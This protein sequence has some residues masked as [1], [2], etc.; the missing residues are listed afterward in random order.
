[1]AG[2]VIDA[3]RG[4]QPALHCPGQV[5]A[6][7]PPADTPCSRWDKLLV[8]VQG[9]DLV[10][11]PPADAADR[12]LANLAAVAPTH[13][14][15]ETGA[16]CVETRAPMLADPGNDR[17]FYRFPMGS[18]WKGTLYMQSGLQALAKLGKGSMQNMLTQY[19]D[20]ARHRPDSDAALIAAVSFRESGINAWVAGNKRI[21]T[22]SGGGLDFLGKNL[23]LMK[24]KY[25]PPGYGGSWEQG[26]DGRNESGMEAGAAYLPQHDLPV[27]YGAWLLFAKDTFEAAARKYGFTQDELDHM[28]TDARRAWVATFFAA[29]GGVEHSQPHG[30]NAMQIGGVT[31]LTHLKEIMAENKAKGLPDRGLD[32]ILTDRELYKYT[33]VRLAMAVVGNAALIEKSMGLR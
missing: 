8:P 11:T 9:F 16:A 21:D 5:A 18:Q 14:N 6:P 7:P 3:T 23:G 15:V 27:A 12:A 24:S 17:R 26:Y 4:S 2:Q 33:N 28:S 10:S 1:M 13:A 31:V 25:L 32:D 29:G 20:L 30:N 22:Y 19:R